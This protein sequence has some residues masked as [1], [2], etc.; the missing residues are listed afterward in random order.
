M[1]NYLVYAFLSMVL[2]VGGATG[3]GL[4][5]QVLAQP[6][7][8]TAEEANT[9]QVVSRTSRSVVFIT[10]IQLVN[11]YFSVEQVARGT[12]SGFVWDR[13]GH[14]VTNYHVIED[15][16]VFA[17]TL[18]DQRVLKARLVGKDTARDIAVLSVPEGHEVLEPLEIGNSSTLR[19]G[20]KVIAI[21][22]PFGLDHTVTTGIVSALGRQITGVGGVSIR[23]I[24]QTDAAINPGN[25]GGPLLD[26]GGR[27]VGM[28][29]M[30]Y[31]STGS[32]TGIG[33]AVP[34]NTISRLVP[35]II[36][37]GK[38]I[39]A[40][41]GI[42]LLEDR[43][44]DRIGFK[45]KGVAVLAVARDSEAQ[46]KGVVGIRRDRWGRLYLGDVIVALN[47]QAVE[48]YD[49]LYQV[50]EQHKVGEV[51]TLTLSRNGRNRDLQWVLIAQ[52]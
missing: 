4:W 48:S 14:I 42:S 16:S 15:G 38:V 5:A 9:I 47:R 27:L 35:Q 25:S 41:L 6:P 39:R 1:R 32:S 34:V 19:V 20:Q 45:G 36:R 26:S 23:D 24:I 3:N 43:V 7:D 40:G 46:R 8:W 49:D 22:N 51:V 52:E 50:L 29:T 10:N 33:F 21:G 37:Y 11:D 31:S 28:N 44:A 17:V 12:G 30:I 18:P 2:M 13:Q